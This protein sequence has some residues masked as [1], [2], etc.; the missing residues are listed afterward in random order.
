MAR[1]KHPYSSDCRAMDP[2]FGLNLDSI[3]PLRGDVASALREDD[4]DNMLVAPSMRDEVEGFAK[5]VEEGTLAD[6]AVR[7]EGGTFQMPVGGYD[8]L[9]DAVREG[10]ESLLAAWLVRLGL[11]ER[12]EAYDPKVHGLDALVARRKS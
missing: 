3:T 8:G 9:Y 7:N 11:A 2:G 6:L 12:T 4:P 1:E 5:A 10:A